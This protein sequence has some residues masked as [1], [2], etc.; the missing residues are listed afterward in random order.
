MVFFVFLRNLEDFYVLD[1]TE[2]QKTN[3][4]AQK[5]FPEILKKLNEMTS[6]DC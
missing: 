4:E 2:P 5:E 6:S 3:Q 1:S